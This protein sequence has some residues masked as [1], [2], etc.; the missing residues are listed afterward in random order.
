MD[1]LVSLWLPILVSA[2]AVWIAAAAAWMALPHHRGDYTRL[3][4][5]DAFMGQVRSASIPPGNYT[6]PH[7]AS[8]KESTTPEG[9]A[10]WKEGPM[11]VLTVMPLPNMGRNMIMSF[12]VYLAVSIGVAYLGS[13]AL[14]R[15]A[16]FW[17]V[18][19]VLGTAGILA[20][21][22]AFWPNG[23]WFGTKI[24]AMVMCTVDGV[25]FGLITGAIFAAM[26][27]GA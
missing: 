26:W 16:D 27:P 12:L 20:Y 17:R 15:G 1:M 4:N 25:V 10:K 18:M 7:F 14:P 21:C 11:G 8:H 24:R 19:Q 9:K 6:F 5:E 13:V 3:P 22:F 23:I 2:A